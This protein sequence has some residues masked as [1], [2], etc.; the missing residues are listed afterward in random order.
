MFHL[1][2]VR[3]SLPESKTFDRIM[4]IRDE[5]QEELDILSK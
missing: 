2:T 4:L 1:I 5:F 3:E